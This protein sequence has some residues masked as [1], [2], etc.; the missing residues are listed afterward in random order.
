MNDLEVNTMM[1]KV[2][3]NTLD[4]INS[5][6]DFVDKMMSEFKAK[7][8]ETAQNKTEIKIQRKGVKGQ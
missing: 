7:V 1:F 2:L 3:K 6:L 4:G 5:R 8:I